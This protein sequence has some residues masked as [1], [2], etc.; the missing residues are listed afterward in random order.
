M[1]HLVQDMAQPQHARDE[2]HGLPPA[3]TYEKYI[4]ARAT[5]APEFKID[6]TTVNLRQLA[7][8]DNAF[9]Q[10]YPTIPAF[11]AFAYFWSEGTNVATAR[12]MADYSSRGFFTPDK[13]FG[14]TEFSLP[15]SDLTN[16]TPAP[17]TSGAGYR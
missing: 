13:N 17:I 15:T 10:S 2:P 4:D 7:P 6:G 14:N 16:Y 5:G 8:F 1:L 12:G 11:N 9:Y 3:S